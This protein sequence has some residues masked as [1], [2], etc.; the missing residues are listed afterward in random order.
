[1]GWVYSLELSVSVVRAWE[2]SP[3]SALIE[4]TTSLLPPLPFPALE[5]SPKPWCWNQ[6]SLSCPEDTDCKPHLWSLSHRWETLLAHGHQIIKAI[7]YS[8]SHWHCPGVTQNGQGG[9]RPS[10]FVWSDIPAQA[11][12][13]KA[14]FAQ[15][16]FQVF[17]EHLWAWR[18]HNLPG[19]PVQVLGHPHRWM[20]CLLMLR[21]S[22]SH[23]SLCLVLSL[24]TTVCVS[25]LSPTF[26]DLHPWITS[27]HNLLFPG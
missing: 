13:P 19:Q 9:K 11:W 20:I 1:M 4:V 14:P 7:F 26:R 3:M 21:Q 27:Y 23:T 6:L 8:A 17:L 12:P 25:H 22:L 18:H 15:D 5:V 2:G 10:V 16:Q 24:L